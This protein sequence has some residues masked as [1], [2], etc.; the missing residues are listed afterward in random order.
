MKIF[1]KFKASE[2]NFKFLANV[3]L[4]IS[5]GTVMINSAD[6][7]Y[8]FKQLLGFGL[9]IFLMIFVSLI[10]YHFVCK[11]YIPIYVFN[12]LIMISVLIFGRSVGGA[13]RWILIGGNNGIQFQPSEFSKICMI[14]FIASLLG[15]FKQ[16]DMLNTARCLIM[17]GASIGFELLL[18][19]AEPDLSTTI[20]VTL[21]L[22]TM[23]YVSG[24]SY[25][26]IGIFALIVIPAAGSFLW[27]IQRPD[28]KLLK[29]YQV[30][31]ILQFIYPNKYG[32]DMS[33]QNNSIMAIGSGQL[34]GKGL[35]S[36]TIATVKDANFISEQQTDFIFS[37]IGEEL[38]FIG[39][40]FIIAMILLLVLQCIK[41]ARRAQDPQG[42]LIACGVA[43]LVGYQ[44][45]INIA[46]ATGVFPNTGIPLPFVSYGLSSL[47][48]LS[49][50]VGLLLN[51]SM[52]KTLY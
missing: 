34:T 24:L 32:E 8:T 2:Y 5:F 37:V 45:F 38:G 52:Q 44:S 14:I 25:K 19:F 50:G 11:L 20:C 40:V 51:I 27:Y 47:L 28:Q 22:L 15:W 35:S 36:S 41:I 43:C 48:S 18:I 31:R 1:T 6:S 49:I 10:D 39:S 12:V 17:V 3:L 46:V 29:P 33:P 26:I 30:G 7:S 23:I 9:A 21:I 16:K 13:K 42:M 4:I